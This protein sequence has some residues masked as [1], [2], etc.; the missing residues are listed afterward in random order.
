MTEK[1]QP[2]KKYFVQFIRMGYTYV[3]AN[4]EEE[5]ESIADSKAENEIEWEGSW[6]IDRYGTIV[7]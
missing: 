3:Y 7:E 6:S 1:E 4:S 5:A 2:K